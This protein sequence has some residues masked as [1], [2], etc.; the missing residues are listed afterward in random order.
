MILLVANRLLLVR[1]EGPH[2]DRRRVFRQINFENDD[3]NA[4]SACVEP[5]LGERVIEARITKRRLEDDQLDVTKISSHLEGVTAGTR[6]SR[7]ITD[8]AQEISGQ[9]GA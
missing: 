3:R 6:D 4:R 5:K 2:D 7:S 1:G 8:A 9:V